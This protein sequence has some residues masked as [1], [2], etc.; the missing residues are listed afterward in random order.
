[1]K[2]PILFVSL[3]LLMFQGGNSGTPRQS[4]RGEQSVQRPTNRPKEPKHDAELEN[5][6]AAASGVPAEFGADVLIRLTQ[7]NKIAQRSLKVDL[8]MRAFYLAD[9]AQQ[10]VK[11]AALAGTTVDSRS[12]Y[13]AY[14]FD[15]KLDRLSLQSRVVAAMVGLD[16]RSARRLFSE[17]R[18]SGLKS[19]TCEDPLVYDLTSFYQ[20]LTA[21]MSGGFTSKE[22]AEGVD[23]AFLESYVRDIQFH[24]QVGP[25]AQLLGEVH[26]P[27]RQRREMADLFAGV[28]G[29]VRGDARSFAGAVTVYKFDLVPR[30]TRLMN[31]LEENGDSSP[32]LPRELRKYLVA[33]IQD[34][35][36]ADLSFNSQDATS[37]PPPVQHFNEWLKMSGQS[38]GIG[39]ID[40]DEVRGAQIRPGPKYHEYWR[41]PAA[42]TLL[43]GIQSLRWGNRKDEALSADERKSSVWASQL[44]DYL[45]QLESWQADD[46]DSPADFFHQKCNLYEALVELVPEKLERLKIID[47]FARFLELNAFQTESRMEW[48]LHVESFFSRAATAGAEVVAEVIQALLSSRDPTLSLYARLERW[49]PQHPPSARQ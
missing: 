22:R 16:P 25:V 43:V 5:I 2:Q 31:S 21:L 26:L 27:T 34:E 42:R 47:A 18:I 23:Q 28:L 46:Q 3:T 10:R 30:V 11:Q 44:S 9:S 1:M 33:N 37:L 49:A 38:A 36:C 12:G 35:R 39:P 24:A 8:L 14:A 19:L 13:L 6:I 40:R 4:L 15:N 32:A 29:R 48:F 41:S 17:I 7:S 20:A 45:K